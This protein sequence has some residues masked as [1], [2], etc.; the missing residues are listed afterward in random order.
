MQGQHQYQPDLFSQIDYENLI[1]KSHLLRRIDEVLNL[2]FLQDFTRPLYSVEYG[3]PSIAPE[4]F[5]R[6]VL[7]QAIY[8]QEEYYRQKNL[9]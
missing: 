9:Q 6:M 1:P 3:R 8:N 2:R 4:I 5:V 7:L